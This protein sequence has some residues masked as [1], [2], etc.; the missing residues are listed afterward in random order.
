[1]PK[2][3]SFFGVDPDPE[4]R[5]HIF[6]DESGTY[7]PHA[8]DRWLL[9]GVLLVPAHYQ[10]Q[11]V[12]LLRAIREDSGYF[13][14]VH[15]VA[16]RKSTRGPKARCVAGWLNAYATVMSEKCFF[17]CLAV[18]TQSKAFNHSS[19]GEPYHAYN[20]F[21]KTA[22]VGAIAWSLSGVSR[23][24]ILIHSHDK[25]RS[26]EDN[27][28]EYLPGAVFNRVQENSKRPGSK[29]P[30]LRLIS[31][32]VSLVP[33]DPSIVPDALSEECELIQL[34]DLL[35]SSMGQAM[36]MT[37]G[38]RGKIQIADIVSRWIRDTRKAP[39]LQEYDL[40][41]RYSLSCYPDDRGG[42]YDPRLQVAYRHQEDLF[43]Y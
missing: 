4:I 15:F 18:D 20:Y 27:F 24:A 25:D 3:M 23:S 40:H 33:S 14:E 32:T 2:Q 21:A 13:E 38:Q 1:M 5:F 16:L 11:S 43:E 31:N 8:G 9:H 36:Q 37:S 6:H 19:F 34:S 7:V 26:D 39:W 42:F 35:T 30:S 29:Y 41:R 22:V 28:A 17:H 10:S 12:S